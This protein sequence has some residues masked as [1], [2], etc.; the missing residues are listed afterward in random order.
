MKR[1]TLLAV[2]LGLLLCTTGFTAEPPATWGGEVSVDVVKPTE[3]LRPT[4]LREGQ[5]RRERRAMGGTFRNVRRIMRDMQNEGED[6][7]D[8]SAETLALEVR[9]RL[10]VENPQAFSDAGAKLGEFD[11]DNFMEWLIGLI[12][13]IMALFGGLSEYTPAGLIPY[14]MLC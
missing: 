1:F 14:Y 5:T 13:L 3:A 7:S 12:Q 4:K 10:Q 6:L 9:K 8:Y 2:L 11:W